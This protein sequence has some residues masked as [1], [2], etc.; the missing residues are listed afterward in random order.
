MCATIR[1]LFH[2]EVFSIPTEVHLFSVAVVC[3]THTSLHGSGACSHNA[4]HSLVHLTPK[5]VP[6]LH[7]TTFLLLLVWQLAY[8]EA[9]DK[10]GSVL[11]DVTQCIF[12]GTSAVGKSSLKHLLVHNTPKAVKTSTAVMATPEVVTISSEQYA[13]EGGSSAWQLVDDDVMGKSL[14]ECV[15]SKAYSEETEL[16]QEHNAV[17]RVERKD[18][19][20]AMTTDGAKES[21][22]GDSDNDVTDSDSDVTDSDS[23]VTDSDS[24]VF[25]RDMLYEKHAH[26]EG[27]K[28]I[29]LKDASFIHLLDTGGQPSFQDALPLLLDA[30]CTYIQVFNAA[31]DL[32]QP[33]PITYRSDDHTEES[34]PPSAETGWEMMLRSFSSMQ[35]M[36]LKCSKEL[37]TIQQEGG[38]LPQMHIFVVGTFKDQL[39]EKGR[40]KE[41]VKDI[42]KRLRD[43]EGKPY[44]RC[45]RK[46]RAGQPFYLINNMA[47]K[48]ED[49]ASVNSL[50]KDL[51]SARYSFK[52]KVP[53]R[54]YICKQYTQVNPQ[55]FFQFQDL[56]AFCLK[57]RFIDVNCAD[58]QFHS[59]LKLFSLLGFYAFFD[60][61]NVP[62]EAT[63]I[64]T[65]KGVFLKEVSKL[66]AIQ[67]LQTPR[68]HAV[69]A[70]KQDGIISNNMEIFEELGIIAEVDR[71]WFLAA[72]EHVGLL[73][74][75]A[76]ATNHS[77]SY[78]MPIAL[79]QGK[80]KLPD[81][82]S[83][84]SLC[85][86]F[87]FHSL[88]NPRVY[89]DLPRGVFCR[90]AVQLS[91]GQWTPIPKESDR[92]TVK[93]RS[94]EFDLY[95]TEA[96]GFI[97]LT[98][99]LV[100]ELEGKEPLTELHKLCHQLYDTLH[101]SIV[102]SAEDVVGEQFNQTAKIVFG[103]ECGCGSV[104]HL[105]I[106]ATPKAKS[107]LCQATNERHKLLNQQRI[108]FAPVKCA[109][110]SGMSV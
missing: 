25:V 101:K 18:N 97:S 66:L 81:H 2:E 47:D 92:T 40:L 99:V 22:D 44:Y 43:L 3:I 88:D 54:W 17:L 7:I 67:F 96:P 26:R 89:T 85:V 41:A 36:A 77:A 80:T 32:D 107:L 9:L 27:G 68:C 10:H 33:I 76:S 31:R 19:P 13:V 61:K 59:L 86:T 91:N 29:N 103:F 5:T 20:P 95:L 6:V 84:A 65:D 87:S 11:V 98:P 78:F 51:S 69:E 72:L 90:L 46:D 48:E 79:P 57:H 102:P 106:L 60:L 50:R 93:F 21:G 34:L 14:Y 94:D 1:Y 30:P 63:C 64:C 75:Y 62:D 49:R 73:A 55:K 74:R 42:S 24:E 28:S 45:I 104:P 12:T 83:V 58:E 15:T 100:E 109:E 35:T 56:K 71:S 8:K 4:S 52:L 105:A 23:E 37:A 38:Q 82:G 110:V 16:P 108:W 39:V 70:F 53:L